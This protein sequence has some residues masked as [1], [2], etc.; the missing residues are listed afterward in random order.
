[1]PVEIDEVLA[2][3][4]P[5]SV[6]HDPLLKGFKLRGD[7]A[8]L[9]PDTFYGTNGAGE[10]GYY[11][12][13]GAV[14]GGETEYEA[15]PVAGPDT[16][17]I[18]RTSAVGVTF[19]R[20]GGAG[21]NTEGTLTV[22]DGFFVSQVFIYFSAAQAPAS[23]YFLNVDTLG[24]AKPVNGSEATCRPA[25]GTVATSPASF[26]EGTP[27]RNYVNSGT[28]QFWDVVSVDD[29]GTRVR[30]RYKITNYNQQAGPSA[31]KLSMWL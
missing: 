27:M 8:D 25:I 14:V 4:S 1:M 19:A 7:Q 5:M 31:S 3:T 12:L 26:S 22:P 18:V 29:N 23:T 2:P 30:V 17:C 20:T 16:G 6:L 21:T 13:A 10:P 15:T 11:P 24:T 9:D 28:P